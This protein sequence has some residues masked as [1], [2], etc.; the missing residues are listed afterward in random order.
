[1]TSPAG[2]APRPASPTK[3]LARLLLAAARNRVELLSLE[4][5]ESGQELVRLL[6]LAVAA[7]VCGLLAGLSLTAAVVIML[8]NHSPAAVLLGL[9]AFQAAVGLCLLA[10]LRSRH[11]EWA[12][13]P[14]TIRQIQLDCEQLEK[15]VV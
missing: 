5:E 8:W 3:A 10:R 15:S 14:E 2:D 12:I 6:V 1:M 7:A 4:L 9:A 11:R 13:V